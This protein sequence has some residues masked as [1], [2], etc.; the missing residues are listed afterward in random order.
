M[1]Q[2]S[3]F[4][5]NYLASYFIR[6]RVATKWVPPKLSIAW[7]INLCSLYMKQDLWIFLLASTIRHIFDLKYIEINKW[8][9]SVSGTMLLLLLFIQFRLL[10]QDKPV[11]LIV[12]IFSTSLNGKWINEKWAPASDTTLLG[13]MGPLENLPCSKV[14]ELA[15]EK[16]DRNLQRTIMGWDCCSWHLLL[17]W[18]MLSY[19]TKPLWIFLNRSLAKENKEKKKTVRWSQDSR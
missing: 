5:A 1:P 2:L 16:E 4:L 8:I 12:I 9:L 7:S 6:K 3:Q 13:E 18:T 11:D 15:G 14:H 19:P 10:K 17:V